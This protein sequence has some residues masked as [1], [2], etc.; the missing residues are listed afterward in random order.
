MYLYVF[1]LFTYYIIYAKKKQWQNISTGFVNK[2]YWFIQNIW[3]KN[4]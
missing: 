3:L 1:I 2:I 4:Y